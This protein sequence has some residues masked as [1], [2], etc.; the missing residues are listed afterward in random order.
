MTKHKNVERPH[1]W[2]SDG[3]QLI[4]S[5]VN[6]LSHTFVTNFDNLDQNIP[7]TA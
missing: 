5:I 2:N 3:P 7:V 1:W 6:Q 4:T